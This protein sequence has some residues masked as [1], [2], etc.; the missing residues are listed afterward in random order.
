MDQYSKVG[1]LIKNF[2]NIQGVSRRDLSKDI[3]HPSYISRLEKGDRCP[4]V[5]ILKEIANRLKIPVSYFFDALDN[6]DAN[7]LNVLRKEIYVLH[8]KADYKKMIEV[9]D[10][11]LNKFNVK[12]II[13]KQF[14]YTSRIKALAIV[15]EEYD[16]GI[17]ELKKSLNELVEYK[18]LLSLHEF[19]IMA[20]IGSLYIYKREFLKANK[21][22][23]RLYKV[24]HNVSYRVN[25]DSFARFHIKYTLLCLLVDKIKVAKLILDEGLILCDKYN[26]S[27]L[28]CELY[29]LKG[30]VNFLEQKEDLAKDYFYKAK[31]LYNL[32]CPNNKDFKLFEAILKEELNIDISIY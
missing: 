19:A 27:P 4:N 18:S 12:S 20:I 26:S 28:L 24:R 21:I 23:N 30:A 13:D 15:N 31:M 6:D 3:C 5:I 29:L 1:L 17:D 22:Y 32:L 10:N 7:E 8:S 11:N 25:F 9:I 2:R 16:K 14:F